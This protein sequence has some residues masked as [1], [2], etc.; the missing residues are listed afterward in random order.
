MRVKYE[1]WLLLAFLGGILF[2]TAAVNLA[3][4]SLQEQAGSLSQVLTYEGVTGA[5]DGGRLLRAVARQR[6]VE[7]AFL[8]ILGLTV[9][10]R[11]AFCAV[12]GWAGMSAAAVLSV[13]TCREGVFGLPV[14]LLSILPQYLFYLPVW[15]FL[16]GAAGRSAR[17]PVR[18]AAAGICLVAAGIWCETWVSPWLLQKILY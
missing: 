1:D 15:I 10:A 14:Y 4:A 7:L 2:G 3:G 17:L 18:L 5:R 11:P 12:A 9:I 6:A 16:A 13:L 8:W